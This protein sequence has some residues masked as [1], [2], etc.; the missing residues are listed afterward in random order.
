MATGTNQAHDDHDHGHR[1]G[2]D[3]LG[4]SH[5][6]PRPYAH[7]P[8]DFGFT[9]ADGAGSGGSSL[10]G[11]PSTVGLGGNGK[12]PGNTGKPNESGNRVAGRSPHS[13]ER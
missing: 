5:S 13:E 10:T 4:R 6:G 9:F 12:E 8:K 3:H 1:D 2:R 11:G 7:T